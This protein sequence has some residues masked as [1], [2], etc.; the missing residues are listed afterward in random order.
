MANIIYILIISIL[1]GCNQSE[2]NNPQKPN[3]I[4]ILTDDQGSIDLN[5]YGSSDLITPNMDAIANEGIRFTQFYA[6]SPVCSP[7]RA[8]LMTGRY[9]HFAGLPT[10]AGSHEGLEGMPSNQVTLAEIFKEA[11]YQTGHIGKWHLGYKPE[12]M[13]NGQ[14]FDYSFGHMGGC[15]D[16][17]SHYFYWNPPNKHDLCRNNKEV[18]Y[19][20][21]FFPD[22]MV[23]E[24]NRFIEKNQDNPF[25]LYWAINLPHYPLQ[26]TEKWREAYENSEHPR[27]KYAAFI[28]TMDEKIGEVLN[29]INGLG[30]SDNTIVVFQSDHG[31][32]VEARTFGGGGNAGPY[33]GAKTSLFEGGIRIPAMIKWPGKIPA[34]EVRDQMI[35]SA[36]WFPTLIKLAGLEMPDHPINGKSFA[37]IILLNSKDSLHEN[38]HW[39][40]KEQWA[41]RSGKWKLIGNPVDPVNK[42]S[43]TEKDSLFLV[44]LEEDVS[45]LHNV[46]E[47]N[48]E[49]V[50]DLLEIH[51]S[52]KKKYL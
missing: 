12:T 28:S 32:S 43:L 27:D 41:V 13:P 52:W 22:L 19:D 7:S 36:D 37:S 39:Q 6:G 16:N 18:W 21:Q 20:G 29:K 2:T 45:E 15:I 8:C 35:T 49:K 17:Y 40:F 4:I 24:V 50:N 48:P 1:L 44:N 38:F 26:G 3:V 14:G 42:G 5:C 10:N 30:L 33:R 51:E 9:P 11:G 23:K 47:S 34:G 46:A 31:H 25:F